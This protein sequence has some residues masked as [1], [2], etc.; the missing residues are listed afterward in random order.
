MTPQEL[1]LTPAESLIFQHVVG[2]AFE[3]GILTRAG[4][5]V[6]ILWENGMESVID[7]DLPIWVELIE[8]FNLRREINETRAQASTTY[9]GEDGDGLSGGDS[10]FI[11][12]A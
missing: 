4:R 11:E 10:R 9:E 3:T 12:W 5:V 8:S 6:Q 7:T 2:D 1:A